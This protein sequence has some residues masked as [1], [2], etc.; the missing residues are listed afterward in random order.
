MKNRM[1]EDTKTWN[2]F[3]GCL[4]DCVYCR[5]SFQQ[6]AKRQ[7]NNCTDCYNYVPHYHPERLNKIPSASI[8]FVCG[9]SDVSFCRKAYML[10]I[11]EAI[12]KQNKRRIEAIKKQYKRIP[13]KKTYFFQS[14]RPKYFEPFLSELPANAIILTTLETNRDEGY[15]QISK[16]PLPTV[17]YEQF[18]NLDYPRK[19]VTIEPVLDFDLDVF[20]DWIK[21]INPEYVWLGYNSKPEQVQM[22][23]PD[24]EKMVR[25]IAEIEKNNIPIKA[26]DLR[27]LN[28]RIQ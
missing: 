8:I 28:N 21:T 23:E 2:P 25:F 11:I 18:K 27:N 19:V 4:F 15:R 7:K 13:K 16:A 22:P 14:K 24:E 26:K 20:V 9:N 17:R 1:Y 5:P 3:K 10:E 6:Q 12:K